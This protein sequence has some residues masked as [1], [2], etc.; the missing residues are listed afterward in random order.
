MLYIVLQ[1]SGIFENVDNGE[2]LCA[3]CPNEKILVTAGTSTVSAQVVEGEC[4]SKRERIG[5]GGN[6]WVLAGGKEGVARRDG[7]SKSRVASDQGKVREIQGQGNVR[8]FY[9]NW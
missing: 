2:I 4:G 7:L 3:A 6:L 9:F 5:I 1:A 8:E